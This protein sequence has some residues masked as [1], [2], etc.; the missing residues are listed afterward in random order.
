MEIKSMQAIRPI[1]QSFISPIKTGSPWD[2][3]LWA[4]EYLHSMI[5]AGIAWLPLSSAACLRT[6]VVTTTCGQP[7]SSVNLSH[8]A[9]LTAMQQRSTR[10]QNNKSGDLNWL[11][12]TYSSLKHI[13]IIYTVYTIIDYFRQI[14]FVCLFYYSYV[15]N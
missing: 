12:Y 2:S 15:F 14:L 13:L 11:L 6:Q 9:L 4:A 8:S 7:E 10:A 5:K 3:D 1:H